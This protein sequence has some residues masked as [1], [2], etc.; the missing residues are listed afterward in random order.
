MRGMAGGSSPTTR[1]DLRVR[2]SAD[3]VSVPGARRFV[4]DGLA[5]W[6]RTPLIDDAALCVTEM[7]ANAALHSGSSFMDVVLHDLAGPVRVAVEDEGALVPVEA[8][9][10]RALSLDADEDDPVWQEQSTTGRGLAIV[11]MIARSWG[12]EETSHG[13]RVWADLAGEAGERPVRSPE[14]VRSGGARSAPDL[15][16]GLPEGWGVMRMPQVPV[17]LTLRMDQHLDDLV[18]EL[19]LIDTD[20]E[21]SPPR[22]VARLIH[23]LVTRPAWARHTGRRLALDAAAAGQEYVDI[24]MAAP[25]AMTEGIRELLVAAR[26]AD[27]V[28]ERY[29]LLTL[30]AST[31]MDVL[32]EYFTEC[33]VAQL[34]RDAAPVT[35]A[36]WLAGRR[37]RVE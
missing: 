1:P 18:R 22:E 14:V 34:E 8:V 15:S 35:Y 16:R 31:E 3:T 4:R 19:Q 13:R 5:D 37:A 28:C 2:M 21:H 27:R 26:T 12:V 33:M 7:A 6:G 30:A 25:R 17:Q 11:S 36:D 32:R 23:E 10:P 20:A 24:E 29:G 9:T